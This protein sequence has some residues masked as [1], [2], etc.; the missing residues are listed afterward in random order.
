MNPSD[1]N[2]SGETR[3]SWHPAFLEAIQLE[4][5]AY[6]RQLE[7]K[8]EY[9]LTSEPLRIDLLIIKNPK[10]LLITKNIAVIFRGTNIIEYKSPDD[11]ISTGG[12]DIHCERGPDTH[13]DN[14]ESAAAGR[15]E[16]VA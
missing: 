14:R 3:V 7:F 2:N 9:Q 12:G 16:Q 10:N 15:R 1:P 11:Y 13:T 8:A 5:Q 4:L 6:W